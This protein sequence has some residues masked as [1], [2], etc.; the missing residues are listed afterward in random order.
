MVDII[1]I[2]NQLLEFGYYEGEDIPF[3]ALEEV[4]DYSNAYPSDEMI[5]KLHD[6]YGV[7]IIG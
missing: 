4:C 7:T 2:W 3:S 6:L 1:E 5:D